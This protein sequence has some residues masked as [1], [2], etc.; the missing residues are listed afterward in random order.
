MAHTH[1]H[2]PL[3]LIDNLQNEKLAG[4]FYFILLF[5]QAMLHLIGQL[6]SCNTDPRFIESKIYAGDC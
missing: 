1:T 5:L 3:V 2:T 6:L 4:L